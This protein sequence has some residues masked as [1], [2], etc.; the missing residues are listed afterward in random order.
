MVKLSSLKQSTMPDCF[1]ETKDFAACE[2]DP[3][4]LNGL[5]DLIGDVRAVEGAARS[6]AAI[7]EHEYEFHGMC[8]IHIRIAAWVRPIA[9]KRLAPRALHIQLNKHGDPEHEFIHELRLNKSRLLEPAVY[10]DYIFHHAIISFRCFLLSIFIHYLFLLDFACKKK[11]V[12][13][14]GKVRRILLVCFFCLA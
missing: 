14:I 11:G 9:A 12:C 6:G 4:L 13:Q 1:E 3:R 5:E 7:V 10:D 8:R 2:I